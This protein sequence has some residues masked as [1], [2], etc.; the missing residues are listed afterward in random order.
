MNYLLLHVK[1]ASSIVF[2]AALSGMFNKRVQKH[3]AARALTK[4]L[5]TRKELLQEAQSL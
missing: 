5:T 3:P 2:H 4:G 1:E